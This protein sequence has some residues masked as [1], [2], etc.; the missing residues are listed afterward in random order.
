MSHHTD[1]DDHLLDKD[2]TI[3][4]PNTQL[5]PATFSLQISS[6]LGIRSFA[7]RRAD[8]VNTNSNNKRP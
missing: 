2:T 3:I 7:L 6:R 8:A 5:S 4:V 1:D